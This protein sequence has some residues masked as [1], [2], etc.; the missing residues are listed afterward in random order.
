MA[1]AVIIIYARGPPPPQD[2]SQGNVENYHDSAP[3]LS[4]ES[5]FTP[6]RAF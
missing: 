6:G 4:T 1:A 2:I 5:M 3:L